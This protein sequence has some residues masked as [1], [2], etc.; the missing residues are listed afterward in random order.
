MLARCVISYPHPR[1]VKQPEGSSKLVFE[2]Y[3]DGVILARDR[4]GLV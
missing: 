4:I 1:E 2:V 3:T